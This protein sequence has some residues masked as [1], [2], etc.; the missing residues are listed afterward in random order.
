MQDLPIRLNKD[1]IVEAVFEIRFEGT[2]DSIANLLPGRS[3]P[4]LGEE[5]PKIE[6]LP[7]AHFPK[8]VH[9]LDPV[10][11]YRATHRLVG[12]GFVI[13]LGNKVFGLA[14]VGPYV[15]WAHFRAR[16]VRVVELLQKTKLFKSVERFSLKY[17]NVLTAQDE[18]PDL[19][20]L[21]FPLSLGTHDLTATTTRL[22]TEISLDGFLN[23]LQ[24]IPG[25]RA[26]SPSGQHV[27]GLL[28][29]I[30][31]ISE[32]PFKDFWAELPQ[33]LDAAHQTEKRLF[34]TTLTK[35]ALERFEPVWEEKQ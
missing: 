31:T 21:D 4:D 20:L 23:I 27:R 2:T 35:A 34:F 15:G 32:Q 11:R 22:R 6:A 18:L 3:Y 8:E 17:I 28:F 10:L 7:Q 29:D 5:F 14:C 33:L 19:Q 26:L 1:P 12:D 30:D 24:V 16:I 13:L 9:Q 25:T